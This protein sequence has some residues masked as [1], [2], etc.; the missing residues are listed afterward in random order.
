MLTWNDAFATGVADI[1]EQ[2]KRLFEVI[3][4]FGAAIERGEGDLKLEKTMKFLGHYIKIHFNFEEICMAKHRC[5]IASQNKK[6]HTSF[7]EMYKKYEGRLGYEGCSEGLLRELHK[8]CEDWLVNHIC[9]IDTHL[10][11]CV[12]KTGTDDQGK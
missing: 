4:D 2:H 10:K 1:D 11:G 3:N 6:A 5:P 9:R 12:S 7:M 8:M